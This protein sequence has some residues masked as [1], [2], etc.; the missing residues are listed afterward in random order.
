M[1]YSVRKGGATPIG[2]SLM[3]LSTL[4]R[5]G[6]FSETTIRTKSA[7]GELEIVETGSESLVVLTSWRKMIAALLRAPFREASHRPPSVAAT[8]RP[9]ARIS[10]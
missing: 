1:A 5:M 8:G 10:P 3:S 4:V 2:P 9:Q 7:A 6:P